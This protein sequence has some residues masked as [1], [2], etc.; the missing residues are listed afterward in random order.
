MIPKSVIELTIDI[1]EGDMNEFEAYVETLKTQDNRFHDSMHVKN[2]MRNIGVYKML[3]K[4][5][6]K[7]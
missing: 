2:I 3:I 7:Y 5:Y 4:E 1:F 6:E